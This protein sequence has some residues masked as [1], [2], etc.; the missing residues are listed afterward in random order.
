MDEKLSGSYYTPQKTIHFIYNYLQQ[1]HKP[2]K[3]IRAQR[4]RWKVHSTFFQI[5]FC[6][7]Y[8]RC[9]VIPRESTGHQ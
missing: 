2:I 5:Q 7:Q 8:C 6:R 4:W 3:S 9:G 1:Q